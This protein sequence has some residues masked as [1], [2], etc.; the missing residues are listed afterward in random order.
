M[1]HSQCKTNHVHHNSHPSDTRKEHGTAYTM[2]VLGYLHWQVGTLAKSGSHVLRGTARWL[3][4]RVSAKKL[5]CPRLTH[6]GWSEFRNFKFHF[7]QVIS[8]WADKA[9]SSPLKDWSFCQVFVKLAKDHFKW[10]C[11]TRLQFYAMFASKCG[12]GAAELIEP[13]D[14]DRPEKNHN[15]M[16]KKMAAWSWQSHADLTCNFNHLTS[17]DH[18]VIFTAS[19]QD[20]RDI[21]WL[22]SLELDSCK[23]HQNAIFH[24][25][26]CKNARMQES[27]VGFAPV[28]F[29]DRLR[30]KCMNHIEELLFQVILSFEVP[31]CDGIPI[32]VGARKCEKHGISL[33]I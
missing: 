22:V 31:P 8:M 29:L 30:S 19:T 15:R 5:H 18:L 23:M 1:K 3:R 11:D 21:G 25:N 16:E 24:P 33:C 32:R 13:G 10:Y 27:W 17:F 4:A 9:Q 20:I 7:E 14:G 2:L 28:F 6:R 12:K 26:Q